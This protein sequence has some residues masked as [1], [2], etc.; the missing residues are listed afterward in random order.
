MLKN[1]VTVRAVICLSLGFAVALSAAPASAKKGGKHTAAKKAKKRVLV[2]GFQGTKSGEARKA[3]I[4]ALKDDGEYDIGETS[5]AK[6]GGDDKSYASASN[7]ATAVLVGTVKKSGLILSVRNGADGALV[8][9][10][11]VKGDSPSKL[12]KNIADTL[13]LS[14]ADV[15]AQTKPGSAKAD[16][17]K[18]DEPKADEPKADDAEE[19]TDKEKEPADEEAKSE[20]ASAGDA[21]PF[22][23]SHSALEL[24]A[25]LR[26]VHRSFTYHD[27]ADQLYPGRG[28]PVPQTYKLP[29]GPA[30]FINGTIYP[31]AFAT[32]GAGANFGITGG[33]ELNFGTKSVYD[34][35]VAGDPTKT[36]ENT[37]TT[38]ANQY[39]VGVKARIPF[40]VHQLGVVVAYGQQEF[41]LLGDERAPT[42]PD[43]WYKF[44]KASLEGRFRVDAISVGV[45]LGTR[46]VSNTGGL[47][48]DWFPGH[49]KTQEIEAGLSLGYSV[50]PSVDLLVG[51]DLTRYAFNFNPIPSSLNPNSNP[52]PNAVI[53]G[54]ATDQ[55]I[56]G[57][58]GARYSL[59]GQK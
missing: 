46:L 53:A 15:I 48:R 27:T 57:F 25:G 37:L 50:A 42:V 12:S 33:Y 51:F 45:H 20:P 2:G 5:D 17:P 41:N 44:I 19:K 54:G 9:D 40:S 55:Y 11:E 49:V 34:T 39:F 36:Q 6:P 43:V 22:P 47:E 14:V 8:Q 28:Y 29:L 3:V 7:G 16:E 32:S 38:A 4:A 21:S 56:S 10:V 58:F 31:G 30:L 18:A 13:G 26:A 23:D 35:P 1:N 59:P 24:E 52:G